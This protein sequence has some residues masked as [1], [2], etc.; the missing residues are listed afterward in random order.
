MNDWYFSESSVFETICSYLND[1][2]D[3]IERCSYFHFQLNGWMY[4]CTMN[5]DINNNEKMPGLVKN[6]FLNYQVL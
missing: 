4:R 5:A 1:G 2:I 6:I 3:K